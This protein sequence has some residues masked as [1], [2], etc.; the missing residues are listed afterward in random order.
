MCEYD[1]YVTMYSV[2]CQAYFCSRV[3]HIRLRLCLQRQSGRIHNA[4][5]LHRPAAHIPRGKGRQGG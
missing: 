4:S 1:G 2:V 5:S 3:Q